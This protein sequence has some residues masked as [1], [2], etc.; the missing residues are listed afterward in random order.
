MIVAVPV[1]PDGEV[2]HSWGKAP[3]VAVAHTS[4]GVITGWQEFPVGWDASHDAGTHG[5]HHA[6]VVRFLRAEG[7][8]L[9]LARHVGDGM[10]RMLDSMGIRLILGVQGDARQA[11]IAAAS[12]DA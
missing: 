4:D 12:P 1:G 10:R 9:V 11:V 8:Q 6:T 7:I 5:S 3:V 2:G